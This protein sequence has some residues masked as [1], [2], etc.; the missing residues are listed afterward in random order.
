MLVRLVLELGITPL[1]EGVETKEE[2]ETLQQMGFLL[3]QG[4]FYGRPASISNYL[5]NSP[6]ADPS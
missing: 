4:F 1:A 3:G 5:N 6:L 2:H